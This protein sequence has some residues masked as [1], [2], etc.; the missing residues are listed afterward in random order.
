MKKMYQYID[1][2]GKK[3][4]R[5]GSDRDKSKF[6]NIGKWN[7]FIKPLIPEDCGDL[8]FL[9]IGSNS[10][11]F[12]KMAEDLGFR[13]V[14]G[15]EMDPDRVR[16]S[17]LYRKSVDGKF[18]VIHQEMDASFDWSKIPRLGLTLIS[19]THYYMGVNDFA[20]TIN[21]LRNRSL[22]CLIVSVNGRKRSGRAGFEKKDVRGFFKDWTEVDIIENV[23]TENDPSPREGMFG[24]L[25]KSNL[26]SISVDEFYKR[27]SD[28]CGRHQEYRHTALYPALEEFYGK[29]VTGA[30][31]DHRTIV[32]AGTKLYEY[33][34]RTMKSPEL[35]MEYLVYKYKLAREIKKDDIKYL[36]YLHKNDIIADGISRLSVAKALGYK[37]V[38]IKRI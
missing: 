17:N 9:E 2:P 23:S 4:Q 27:E 19:N 37:R 12:L 8:P 29:A 32:I 35:A 6:W 25:F 34:M 13:K 3:L 36:I 28:I 33:Y 20:E 11:L 7:I 21:S 5:E 31:F 24:I 38:I 10:G 30:E 16:T 22:Y 1:L 15:V 14:I 26:D 18:H